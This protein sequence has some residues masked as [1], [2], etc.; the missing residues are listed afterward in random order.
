M[1]NKY[2]TEFYLQTQVLIRHGAKRRGRGSAD[3]GL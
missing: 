3:S 1:S 2:Q